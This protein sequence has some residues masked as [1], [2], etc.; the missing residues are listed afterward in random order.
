ML[1]FVTKKGLPGASE[2]VYN[3]VGRGEKWGEVGEMG[4]IG[5]DR[6][7]KAKKASQVSYQKETN[8]RILA[9]T[10]PCHWHNKYTCSAW[11]R[12]K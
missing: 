2:L 1:T 6:W 3:V 8:V 4:G 5:A 11:Q 12:K 7:G 9:Q 10:H